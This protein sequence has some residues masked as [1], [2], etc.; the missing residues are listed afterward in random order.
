[1]NGV[2][3][4]EKVKVKDFDLIL[5]DLQMPE[6]NGLDATREINQMDWSSARTKPM[7]VAMTASVLVEDK[8]ICS[9]AGM[10]AHLSKPI[11]LEALMDILE[12][13]KKA[14]QM[15]LEKLCLFNVQEQPVKKHR[16][17]KDPK[18]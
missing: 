15:R 14:K 9:K 16:I 7:I 2:E 6:K 1:M 12:Q 4:V 8:I 3:A 10:D 5:M 13:T 11:R 18:A 17:D